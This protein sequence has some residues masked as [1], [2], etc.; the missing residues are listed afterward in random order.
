MFRANGYPEPVVKRN[1]RGRPT[2]TNTTIESET[3]LKLLLV[4]YARGFIEQIKKMCRPLGVS[5]VMKSASTLRSS[6]VKVKLARP[7]MKNK[8]AV[9]EM[10]C[11][12]CPCVYIRETGRTLEKHLSEHKTA[13]KKND[14]KN[15]IAVHAWQ[16]STRS[17]GKPL[18][19]ARGKRLLEEK[20]PIG[21]TY[22]ATASDLK[23]GL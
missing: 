11:K 15:S 3:P 7:D 16:T 9:Y 19:Q 1:L 4:P 13:V 18:C 6:I 12:A 23:P 8:G 14:P 22:P 5:T 10:P 2:P 17:T 20:G 21:P